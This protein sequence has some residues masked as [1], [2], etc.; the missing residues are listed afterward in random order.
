[1]T[2]IDTLAATYAEAGRFA[3]AV[4]YQKMALEDPDFL[5]S[6]GEEARARLELYE[7][8]R[9]YRENAAGVP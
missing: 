1:M 6:N 2:Y 5:E 7:A 3:D 9:P 4:K 8:G